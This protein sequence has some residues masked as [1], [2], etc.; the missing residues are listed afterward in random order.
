MV[1]PMMTY[2]SS[3]ALPLHCTLHLCFLTQLPASKYILLQFFHNT[4]CSVN[5]SIQFSEM[6]VLRKIAGVI[7]LDCIWNEEIKHRLQQRSIVELVK[8]RREKW[9][10][11][12]IENYTHTLY[13]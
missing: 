6:S 4:H 9:Q 12:V 2:M 5:S 10:A 7:R 13:I 3:L 1:V 8:E 11:K